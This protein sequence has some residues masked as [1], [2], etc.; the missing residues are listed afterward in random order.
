MTVPLFSH[1]RE[2]GLG[3]VDHAEEIRLNLRTK[4]V[5]AGA[6]QEE[7][8][9]L[10]KRHRIAFDER[11]LWDERPRFGHPFRAICLGRLPRAEALGLALGSALGLALG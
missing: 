1:E 3:D 10:L 8:S 9:E 7:V 5:E 2:C 11:Y 4:F 6:Y